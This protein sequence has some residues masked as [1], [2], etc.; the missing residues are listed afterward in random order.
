[1][2]SGSSSSAHDGTRRH[3][4]GDPTPPSTSVTTTVYGHVSVEGVAAA[5]DVAAADV[6]AV[7]VP[8]APS[9]NIAATGSGKPTAAGSAATPALHKHQR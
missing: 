3:A 2:R 4:N 9:G 8:A 6:S 5:V 7:E 1:M